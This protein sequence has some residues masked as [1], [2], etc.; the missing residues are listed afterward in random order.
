MPATIEV[1]A[2]VPNPWI[3]WYALTGRSI[4][5]LGVAK[6]PCSFSKSEL[7]RKHR[8][9]ATIPSSAAHAAETG[10]VETR[11]LVLRLPLLSRLLL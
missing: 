6:R 11:L 9:S 3:T 8:K 2:I 4:Y 7:R 10:D 1:P 5:A